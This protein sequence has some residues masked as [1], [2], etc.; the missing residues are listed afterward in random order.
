MAIRSDDGVAVRIPVRYYAHMIEPLQEQEYDFPYHHL[1]EVA[2]FSETKH[3]FWGYAYAAYIEKILDLLAARSF[4]SLIDIGTGDGKI[5]KEVARRFPG[6]RL[7]GADYSEK[8][9]RFAHAFSPQIEF[10]SSSEERFDAFLLIEVI[11]HIPVAELGRFVA[12]LRKNLKDDGFGIITTPSKNAPL[13]PKHFQHFDRETL[14]RAVGTHFT[15]ESFG[16]LNA[17]TFG[18]RVIARLLANRLFIL[19]YAPAVRFLY[20]LYAKRYAQATPDTGERVFAVVRPAIT[21]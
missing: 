13:I 5:L 11:E 2:P 14:E 1:V 9:L 8:S 12:S 6:T 20:A 21:S 3:L 17:R 19:N 7:V 15:I 10:V 16:Y 18:A 4:A